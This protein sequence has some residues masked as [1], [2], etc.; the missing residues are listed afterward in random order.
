MTASKSSLRNII[1]LGQKFEYRMFDF[2][3]KIS[4]PLSIARSLRA[5]LGRC[6]K[7]ATRRSQNNRIFKKESFETKKKPGQRFLKN[8]TF[9]N[10]FLGQELHRIEIRRWWRRGQSK[11]FDSSLTAVLGSSPC[12]KNPPFLVKSYKRTIVLEMGCEAKQ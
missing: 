5:S 12:S 6:F 10:F 2:R 9:R 3:S 8:G 1:L 4:A 7:A 11:W